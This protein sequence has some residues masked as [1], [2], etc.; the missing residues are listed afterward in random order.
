VQKDV[1]MAVNPMVCLVIKL[2]WYL[3]YLFLFLELEHRKISVKI[4]KKA[5]LS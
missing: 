1:G 4:I 2:S 5:K 3:F